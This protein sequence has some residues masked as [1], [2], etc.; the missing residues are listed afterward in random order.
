LA[1]RLAFVFGRA[2]ALNTPGLG[3]EGLKFT[4]RVVPEREMAFFKLKSM[5]MP[6]WPMELTVKVKEPMVGVPAAVRFA[7][8]TAP[9]GQ[10][11]VPMVIA[12]AVSLRNVISGLEN[13]TCTV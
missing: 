7:A 12:E 6:R 13:A 11:A 5:P 9:L 4:D 1:P 2:T 10:L 3:E 8:Q